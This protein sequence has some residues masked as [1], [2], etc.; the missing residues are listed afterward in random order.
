MLHAPGSD[1]PVTSSGQ[2]DWEIEFVNTI[3]GFDLLN[4]ANRMIGKL[5]GF[6]YVAADIIKK[7]IITHWKNYL[8]KKAYKSGKKI[9]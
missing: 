9:C 1:Y 6:I 3:T 4:Q 8:K 5:C 2:P 7:T